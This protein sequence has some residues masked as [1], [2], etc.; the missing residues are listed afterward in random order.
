M[1][2]DRS[3][4]KHWYHRFGRCLIGSTHG[5]TGKLHE[6][7][8]VMAV[9]R[10]QDWGE[11]AHRRWYV[12]HVHHES[13]KEGHG[14]TVETFQTLAPSDAYH[15]GAG[16]RSGRSMRSD[17]WHR[18]HGWQTRNVVGIG[19]VLEALGGPP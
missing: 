14:A 13:V 16:Y 3:P 18:E 11:T 10:P 7:P 8:G 15:K 12:G 2:V 9:D 4:A 17:L 6:L 19:Q 5:D 1:T